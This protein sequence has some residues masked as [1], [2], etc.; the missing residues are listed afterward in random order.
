MSVVPGAIPF[1]R[2]ALFFENTLPTDGRIH[3]VDV[4]D[5]ATAFAAATTAD[6]VG[7]TLLIAGDDSHLHR[8]RDVGAAL[9]AARGLSN[10][11]P[12]GRPGD[13]DSDENWFVT[14]WLDTVARTAGVVVPAPLVARHAGRDARYC[15]MATLS[16]GVDRARRSDVPQTPSRVPRYAR[17]ATPTHGARFVRGSASRGQT[18]PTRQPS[19]R[20]TPQGVSATLR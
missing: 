9:A 6:V 15:R 8:Q 4:R 20:D 5:V 2:D 14:D 17:A 13:P 18:M 7:E 16:D 11:L 10:V 12:A 19:N 3:T 1:S